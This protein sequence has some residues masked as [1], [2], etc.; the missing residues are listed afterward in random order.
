MTV[1]R[2]GR[3]TRTIP[4]LSALRRKFA[5]AVLRASKLLQMRRSRA[6][7]AISSLPRALS[8]ASVKADVASRA[9]SSTAPKAS[10]A[11]I[12]LACF[13]CPSWRRRG[14]TIFSMRSELGSCAAR[15]SARARRTRFSVWGRS[16]VSRSRRLTISRSP[17]VVFSGESAVSRE[18]YELP[19]S[20]SPLIHPTSQLP[21]LVPPC[22]TG[23]LRNTSASCLPTSD[24]S[25]RSNSAPLQSQAHRPNGVRGTLIDDGY[26]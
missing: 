17:G 20:R 18:L 22:P 7:V 8:T 15:P 26:F 23:W 3:R 10:A 14:R 24:N 9:L 1:R 21:S 2:R 25:N 19:T 16:V 6:S 4:T 5:H 12:S 13:S 11:T